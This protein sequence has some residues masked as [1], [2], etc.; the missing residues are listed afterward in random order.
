M[1]AQPR[2]E[3]EEAIRKWHEPVQF[4]K[5]QF[6]PDVRE[7]S[8]SDTQ[9]AGHFQPVIQLNQKKTGTVQVVGPAFAVPPKIQTTHSKPT[10]VQAT[11]SSPSSHLNPHPPS[12]LRSNPHLPVQPPVQASS[13]PLSQPKPIPLDTLKKPQNKGPSTQNLSQLKDALKD[14][15]EKAKKEEQIKQSLGPSPSQTQ[16]RGYFQ[17]KQNPRP[18]GSNI[19]DKPAQHKLVQDKPNEVPEDVLRRI[20]DLP[21]KK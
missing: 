13:Q 10:N 20:F 6:K 4:E 7:N 17:P 11:S 15:V 16:P 1:F 8:G 18:N 12:H 14:I 21:K 3:V 5:K 2:G 19:Q 9:N